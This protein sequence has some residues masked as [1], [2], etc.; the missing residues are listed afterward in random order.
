MCLL[1][2]KLEN[3]NE[4]IK[5]WPCKITKNSVLEPHFKSFLG[6]RLP[7]PSP[8]PHVVLGKN[9]AQP[10]KTFHFGHKSSNFEN[11]LVILRQTSSY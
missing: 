1:S 10:K 3:K 11:F 8:S 2:T 6:T 9:P 7:V 5:N 4:K